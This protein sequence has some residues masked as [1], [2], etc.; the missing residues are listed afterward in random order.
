MEAC[1][2]FSPIHAMLTS[3][4]ALR[5]APR[6]CLR[7]LSTRRPN[8]L[9]EP[10]IPPLTPAPIQDD[11]EYAIDA[12]AFLARHEE[13]HTSEW[14]PADVDDAIDRHSIFTW[15]ASGVMH[16][17]AMKIV[18]GDGVHFYTADGKCNIDIILCT[19]DR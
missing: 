12:D 11:A 5:L 4:R 10:G 2:R 9:Y 17:G 6:G 18:K 13:L 7:S 14:D 19:A 16:E 15:G 8:D 3:F 1:R